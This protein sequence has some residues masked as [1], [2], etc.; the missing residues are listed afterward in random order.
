MRSNHRELKKHAWAANLEIAKHA[1]AIYNFGNASAFDPEAGLVAIKPSGVAY[2]DLSVE[3]MVVLDLEGKIVEG[4]LKP[5]SDTRTHL[6]L[7]REMRG[8]GGVVHTHSTYATGWAQAATPIPIL[9]TTHA[10]YLD[11]DVP[12]TKLMSAEAAAG[13]Y[14]SETGVQILDCFR[15][16]HDLK[17]EVEGVP[18]EDVS[19]VAAADDDQLEAC[20]LRDGLETCGAH[21]ARGAD[22]EALPC[23]EERL[24]GVDPPSELGHQEA[25]GALLPI[26][27]ERLEAL[28]HAVPGR[29]DLVGIDRVE[30]S[31]GLLRVPE[32]EGLSADE[33][34]GA[35]A[36]RPVRPRAGQV[37]ERDSRLQARGLDRVSWR[38]RHERRPSEETILPDALRR[39]PRRRGLGQGTEG[40]LLTW[41]RYLLREFASHR[42]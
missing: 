42:S 16:L 30:L 21:L 14:E 17:A 31:P 8:L 7:F 26:L 29:R 23:D 9:G 6:M 28:R 15:G 25:E 12:C 20:L 35:A 13:D 36:G 34:P 22:G 38:W 10:D 2:Q 27:V 41:P 1:L 5:S 32:D 19:H 18:A 24:A 37:L 39:P 3:D 4:R 11:E 40:R 33:P